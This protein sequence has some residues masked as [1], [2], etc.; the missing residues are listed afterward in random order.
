MYYGSVRP[1]TLR[2]TKEIPESLTE[3]H[4]KLHYVWISI[5]YVIQYIYY[6][7]QFVLKIMY[8]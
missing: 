4:P 5:C 8:A 3:P 2:R 7:N 6:L 1:R